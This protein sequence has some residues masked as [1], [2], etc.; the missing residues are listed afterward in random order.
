M[1]TAQHLMASFLRVSSLLRGSLPA[2]ADE[3]TPAADQAARKA[4]RSAPA[5]RRQRPH[6]GP[7]Y[8]F[9]MGQ[10][11]PQLMLRFC[12]AVDDAMPVLGLDV[13]AQHILGLHL[14]AIR[15]AAGSDPPNVPAALNAIRMVRQLLIENADG[16]VA[17]VLADSSAKI[18]G[19]GVGK[20]FS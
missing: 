12:A 2:A 9:S 19:D 18:I 4:W 6:R 14:I 1:R 3:V 17:A 5:R 11:V 15:A 10:L 13:S 7:P 20:L 16:P 8:D